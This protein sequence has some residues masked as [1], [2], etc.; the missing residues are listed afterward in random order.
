MNFFFFQEKIKNEEIIFQ[1]IEN[2]IKNNLNNL[3]K[4]NVN[5]IRPKQLIPMTLIKNIN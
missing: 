3:V 5:R 1:E 2:G 4:K